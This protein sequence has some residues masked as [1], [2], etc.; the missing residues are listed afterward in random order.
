MLV[1][2]CV[3]PMHRYKADAIQSLG[4]QGVRFLPRS[5]RNY[6]AFV[7]S[8][9]Y[10]GIG[11]LAVTTP[12]SFTVRQNERRDFVKGYRV[13]RDRYPQVTS[14]QIGN[15]PDNPAGEGQGSTPDDPAR[16][17]DQIDQAREAL[18]PDAWI[19]A[20]GMATGEAGAGY[21]WRISS[22]YRCNS[23]AL[24]IYASSPREVARLIALYQQIGLPVEITEF[25]IPHGWLDGGEH[26][27][28][29]WYSNVIRIAA[30]AGVQS[31]YAF[32]LS[33]RMHGE[34]GL[35]DAHMEPYEAWAAIHDAAGAA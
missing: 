28:A 10:R 22:L 9:D 16:I 29:E 7:R 30:M 4:V 5:N 24:H 27:R 2:C 33:N 13:L 25:G 23:V 6:R 34:Y 17:S 1:G 32:C 14:W 12:E 35:A 21:L 31:A 11:L 26:A 3:D 8:L 18:G 20:P 15:E 19:V